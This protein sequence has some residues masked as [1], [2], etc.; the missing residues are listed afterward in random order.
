MVHVTTG[1]FVG[2]NGRI[3]NMEPVFI[4]PSGVVKLGRYENTFTV[5]LIINIHPLQI[6]WEEFS[7]VELADGFAPVELR[8]RRRLLEYLPQKTA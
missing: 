4:L 1:D 3:I 6:R 7:R 2:Y 5:A 8:G